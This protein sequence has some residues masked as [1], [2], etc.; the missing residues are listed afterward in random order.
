MGFKEGAMLMKIKKNS[1]KMSVA[2]SYEGPFLLCS[3]WMQN[4]FWKWMKVKQFV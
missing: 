2:S 4:D 1:K 3:I